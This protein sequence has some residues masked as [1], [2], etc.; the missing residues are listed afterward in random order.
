MESR[1]K[2]EHPR[3]FGFSLFSELESWRMAHIKVNNNKVALM[4][5]TNRS[6]ESGL[7][8][9]SFPTSFIVRPINIRKA[10]LKPIEKRIFS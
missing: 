9:T 2:N 7:V 6:S 8:V 3:T 4:L 5:K 10:I 1:S